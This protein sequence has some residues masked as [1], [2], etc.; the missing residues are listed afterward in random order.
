MTVPTPPDPPSAAEPRAPSLTSPAPGRA[1]GYAFALAAGVIWGTTGPLSTALYREGAEITDVGF[2]RI[3]V[4][5]AAFLIYGAFRRGIFRID[6]RGLWLIGLGGGLLVAGFEIAFQV[7]ISGAGVASAVALLYTA[8]V[9]VALLAWPILGER[10]G[11][12]R[13]ALATTVM[14]GAA[15]TVFGAAGA[16]VGVSRAGVIGG[17]VSAGCFA[18]ST[19]LARWAVPRYGAIRTLLLTITGGTLLLGIALPLA[20]HTPNVPAGGAAWLF[21][22]ALGGG[23]VLANFAFFAGVRR[24]DAAPASVAATVEPVVGAVLALLL[25]AQGLTWLG[26]LGLGL[27]VGGVAAGYRREAKP[28]LK[29]ADPTAGD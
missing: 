4:A 24:I 8:P 25:F 10:L 18:G 13:L 3:A 11:P 14:A 1:A 12:T 26:W 28:E 5:T 20:G 7:A 27:V 21:I 19:L 29:D 16:D 22:A 9:I 23:T 2:W 6:V 17:L 15:L